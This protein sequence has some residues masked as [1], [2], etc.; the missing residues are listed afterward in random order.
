MQWHWGNIG[1]AV[2]GLSALVVA[3]AA[4]IRGP[5]ALS[6]WMAKQ[7]AQEAAAREEEQ[8]ARLD[9]RRHLNGWSGHGLDTF[10][11]ALVT[12]DDELKQAVGELA[13]GEP[14]SYVVLRVAEGE[15]TSEN[16]ARSLRQLIE[17][18]GS[19][20]RPPTTG[21]REALEAGLDALGVQRAAHG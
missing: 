8:T 17:I 16:R 6:A 20:S 4:L 15:Y 5:A 2:A 3:A 11:V 19:I 12:T 9:R 14:T 7:R 10:G 18:E 13:S 1:S 21:E